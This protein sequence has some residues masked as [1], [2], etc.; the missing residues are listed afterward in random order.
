MRFI[1]KKSEQ[2]ATTGST[3]TNAQVA[4]LPDTDK[5]AATVVR[6]R[7]PTRGNLK[8]KNT[9]EA[10]AKA[11]EKPQTLAQLGLVSK[12]SQF[13]KATPENPRYKTA[14]ERNLTGAPSNGV[15]GEYE[16]ANCSKRYPSP[17]KLVAHQ[18]K[19]HANEL[20]QAF[21]CPNKDRGCFGRFVNNNALRHHIP[22]CKHAPK[23]KEEEAEI[24]KELPQ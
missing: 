5:P 24:K 14:V 11:V 7:K 6:S 15:D 3:P 8:S 20:V 2:T 18:K 13:A 4:K 22:I 10:I 21:L 19:D 12:T 9:G 23:A 16:C 1:G 17:S